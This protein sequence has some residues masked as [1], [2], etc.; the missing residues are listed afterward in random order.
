[1]PA[2][3]LA[4]LLPAHLRE[5]I[6]PGLFAST[7]HPSGS[8]VLYWMRSAVRGHENPALDAAIHLASGAGLPLLVYQ[9]LSERYPYASFRHHAFILEG[10]REAHGELAARGIPAV[11]HLE[12]PGSD[13]PWL[14]ALAGRAALVVT[15]AVPVPFLRRWTAAVRRETRAP[16]VEVDAATLA[17]LYQIPPHRVDRAFR[18]RDAAA[19]RW[20]AWLRTPWPEV[21]E[22]TLAAVGATGV[23]A[24]GAVAEGGSPP[25]GG[26]GRPGDP[27]PDL[28]FDLPFELPFEP[29]PVTALDD[30]GLREALAT[31]RID[32]AIAP[33]P[34][35]R[36]GSTAGYA[37]WKA[38][39]EGGGLARYARDRNDPLR[40]GVSRMSAYLH[41]GHVSPFRLAREAHAFAASARGEGAKGA[42]K[43]L[44]ELLT[45][46]ELAWCWCHH[47][48]DPE[49]LDALP[50]W[51]RTTLEAHAEDPRPALYDRE[52]LARGRTGDPLW[53]AAQQSL[54]VHGELHNN[55]RMTWGKALLPWTPDPAEALAALVDLN[56]RYALDGRDPAS[57]GGILW[58]LGAFDR[59]FEPEAPIL[60]TV[61][62]RDPRTHARRLDPV[63]WGRSTGRPLV[64]DPPAVAVIG[65]GVAGLA[66]AR[67]LADHGLR[68]RVFDK[69]RR[70]GGRISTRVAPETGDAPGWAMD[71]GAPFFTARDPAFQRAVRAWAQAGVVAPWEGRIGYL[72][73][74]GELEPATA[75]TRWV[76]VPAMQS[77]ARHLADTLPA[78]GSPETRGW[79]RDIE[80]RTGVEVPPLEAGPLPLDALAGG[81][82]WVVEGEGFHAV[83][84]TAPPPQAARLLAG[85]HPAL[86]AR[87]EAL[88][89]EPTWAAMLRVEAP[90]PPSPW[91]PSS[92]RTTPSSG[93]WHGILPGPGAPGR[94]TGFFTPPL[95]GARPT[96]RTMRTRLPR[97][98]PGPSWSCPRWW[99]VGAA[100]GAVGTAPGAT[101]VAPGAA[102]TGRPGP[103]LPPPPTRLPPLRGPP[104]PPASSKSGHTAGATPPRWTPGAPTRPVS[105]MPRPGSGWPAMPWEAGGW[106]GPS[107]V[108]RPWPGGSSSR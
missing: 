61:R 85:V 55:V 95:D 11:F 41:H 75:A 77:V 15:E 65:A 35:T 59:P 34:H 66:A 81:G 28:A 18:F 16:V 24:R 2:S 51:A 43:Y 57:Y 106:R 88:A 93:G 40:D 62:P 89:M 25:E 29:F 7:P 45:W 9:G 98:W 87:M 1:M 42:E 27:L 37:R 79:T 108:A 21:P 58:C 104:P 103:P 13:G 84:V 99:A 23:T 44:D 19:P 48:E 78:A 53:D 49:S 4:A 94:G 6:D 56:H 68:V 74:G 105:G 97:S 91:M 10:A 72:R 76:G 32:P 30:A 63:R 60:G 67:I 38:F 20:E 33:V 46:R 64:D 12:R 101:G 3:T 86:A 71:H 96:W 26:A 50:R 5:R 90:A 17:S 54:L 52:T 80:V 83:V 102:A 100:T 22:E 107:G 14:H 82:R 70:V 73:R 92:S 69:G 8:F 31:L 36:G 39:R 47:Q